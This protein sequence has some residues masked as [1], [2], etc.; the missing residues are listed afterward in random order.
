MYTMLHKCSLWKVAGIFFAEP[1][2]VHFIKEISRKINLAHTSVKKHILEL[3]DLGLAEPSFLVFKGY[4]A[5]RENPDFLFYKKINN[6]IM[7][8]NSGLT[9]E[10]KEHY[11]KAIILFGSY[12]KGE[13]IET[14]DIDI[15]I[16]GKKF[17][18]KLE[19]YEK[20]LSRKI[21]LVFKE[22]AAKNLLESIKQGQILFGERDG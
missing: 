13:D 17:S 10:L 16:D 5:K 18:I 1:T 9:E 20:Y 2:K 15:F 12:D 19:K 8:K 14:S 22:E 21:H 3:I 4:K 6:L 7:L 11:P